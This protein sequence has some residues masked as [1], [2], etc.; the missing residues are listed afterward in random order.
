MHAH[1]YTDKSDNSNS[2]YFTRIVTE[3]ERDRESGRQT[4][5]QRDRQTYA[6]GSNTIGFHVGEEF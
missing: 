3:R 2:L 5:R 6:V 1:T 4:D